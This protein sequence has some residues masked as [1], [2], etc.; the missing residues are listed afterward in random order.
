MSSAPIITLA[1][2]LQQLG[3]LNP[4]EIAVLMKEDPQLLRSRI[5]ELVGRPVMTAGDLHH[6]LARTAGMV[7]VDAARFMLPDR[8]F[9]VRLQ[10]KMRTHDLLFL[11]EADATLFVAT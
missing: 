1:T 9:D 4:R 6:A 5:S 11:D 2:A 10:Q 7:E 3:V 8:A